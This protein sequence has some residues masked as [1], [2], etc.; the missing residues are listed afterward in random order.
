MG[1]GGDEFDGLGVAAEGML[2]GIGGLGQD[3]G[4]GGADGS[5]GLRLEDDREEVAGG[6]AGL[7][8]DAGRQAGE[9]QVEIAVE[10]LA[11]H[12]QHGG[13]PVAARDDDGLALLAVL[14]DLRDG[15]GN[16]RQDGDDLDA[17]DEIWAAAE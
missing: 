4:Y 2:P 3:L 17:I 1:T 16:V 12:A 7:E 6:A 11:F 15:E 14:D 8:G 5:V 10:A 9:I 13:V